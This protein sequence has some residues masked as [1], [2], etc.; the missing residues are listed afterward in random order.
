MSLWNVRRS[1]GGRTGM[2]ESDMKRALRDVSH[3]IFVILALWAPVGGGWLAYASHTDGAGNPLPH[4]SVTVWNAQPSLGFDPDESVADPTGLTAHVA[5]AAAPLTIVTVYENTTCPGGP[6]GITFWNPVTN[7]FKCFGVTSG[8]QA[9]VDINRSAPVKTSTSPSA[10][11]FQP[12]D[13]WASGPTGIPIY[14]NFKGTSNFRG[15]PVGSTWGV[16]VDQSTGD[17]FFA[18]QAGGINRLD[19]ATNVRTRWAVGGFPHYVTR[20]SAGRVYAT[21][22]SGGGPGADQI[23]RV[24][25]ATNEVT[26]WN[27]PGAG[28]FAGYGFQTPNGITIDADGNIWFNETASGQVGRLS[29]GPDGSLGTADDQICE[30]SKTGLA[31]P[32]LIATSGSDAPAAFAAKNL[33][34]YLTEGPGNA[35]TI[36]TNKEA[37]PPSGFATC[38]TAA[39]SVSTVTPTTSTVAAFD[40]TR[41]F[42][43]VTITPST[44]TVDGLNGGPDATGTTK[45]AGPDGIPGT[46]DDERIPGVLRFPLSPAIPGDPHFP[47]GMT[48]VA[49]ANTIFGSFLGTDRLFQLTSAAII[50]P[51]DGKIEVPVDIKPQSCPN[52]LNCRDSGVLPVAILGTADFDVTQVDPASV[53]LEGVPPLRSALEDVATPFAPFTGKQD[54]QIDCTHAG[55]DGF[56]DLTLQFDTQEVLNAIGPV[57][58]R[59]CLVLQLTGNLKPEFGGTPI[60]GEDVVRI[61]CR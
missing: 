20:D 30:F 33:Q 19:P 48:D 46:A 16:E 9:A 7:T 6:C 50:P 24:N 36:V 14:V 54:C 37:V 18:D 4:A 21:V 55:P 10:A 12:G 17:V 51:P 35:V 26:R 42:I 40:F 25:P 8:F 27:V 1:R 32:Q 23:V 45:T 29:A 43:T 56:L 58:D 3:V 13:A 44:V 59:A 39:P 41:P 53:R 31:G 34:A 15:Y 22:A 28:S 49:V 5:T 52:P 38:A 60:V 11:T 47:S 61:L 57:E 2:E